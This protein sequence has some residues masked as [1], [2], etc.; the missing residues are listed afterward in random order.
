MRYFGNFLLVAVR[1]HDNHRLTMT[2]VTLG[3]CGIGL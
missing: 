3:D 1:L 2:Q